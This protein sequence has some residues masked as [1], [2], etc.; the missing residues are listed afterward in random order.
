MLDYQAITI[1]KNA[2]LSTC[3]NKKDLDSCITEFKSQRPYWTPDDCP[4]AQ[5]SSESRKR[6]F[7]VGT[8][9]NTKVRDSTGNLV[10]VRHKFFLDF[11]P[12]EPFPMEDFTIEYDANT[13]LFKA[14]F[15]RDPFAAGYNLHYTDWS[16]AMD[17][18]S[19][20][21]DVKNVFNS[22]LTS[23]MHEIVT[24]SNPSEENC[25]QTGVSGED[26]NVYLCGNQVVYFFT[27]AERSDD[28]FF[29]IT[30]LMEDKESD[31]DHFTLAG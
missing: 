5:D 31:I 15:V 7:C 23:S 4:V 3:K 1:E 25:P 16:P 6:N 22:I 30:T 26:R 9:D 2:L 28:L 11:S 27:I 24:F 18:L 14:A 19:R 17:V 20:V 29:T 8:R 10:P 21:R 13:D 12:T